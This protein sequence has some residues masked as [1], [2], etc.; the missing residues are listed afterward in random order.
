M[1]TIKDVLVAVGYVSV[2]AIKALNL[3]LS[4]K[5]KVRIRRFLWKRRFRAAL[6]SQKL[7]K[8]L[9]EE[10]TEMYSEELNIALSFLDVWNLMKR[11]RSLK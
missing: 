7:P 6:K 8:E 11:V 5:L 9:G 2:L 3:Y 4:I 10:L 1:K